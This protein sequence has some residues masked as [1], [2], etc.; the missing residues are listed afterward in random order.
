MALWH[1][2]RAIYLVA[3]I[4]W[5][6]YASGG[7]KT[8]TYE[9]FGDV[10]KKDSLD[11]YDDLIERCFAGFGY[12]NCELIEAPKRGDE[13]GSDLVLQ[14]GGVH[15]PFHADASIQKGEKFCLECCSQRQT[16]SAYSESWR[17]KCP[18]ASEPTIQWDKFEHEFRFARRR[19]TVDIETIHCPIFREPEVQVIQTKSPNMISGYFQLELG[20]ARDVGVKPRTQLIAFNASP[21]K[22]DEQTWHTWDGF[23][24][25][26]SMQSQLQW[27]FHNGL[28]K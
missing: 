7:Y 22:R 4:A 27:A 17:F 15:T 9:I 28:P 6:A 25:Q 3:S 12:R 20:D 11:N 16:K 21:G 23:G 18:I 26:E 10:V 24:L 5:V 14:S 8:G 1:I 2:L 19:T 13:G